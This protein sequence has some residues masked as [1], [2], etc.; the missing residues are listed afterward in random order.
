M[1]TAAEGV[2]E[3]RTQANDKDEDKG[4]FVSE[5]EG[6]GFTCGTMSCLS[7]PDGILA[8]LSLRNSRGKLV[9]SWKSWDV[10][11]RTSARLA[12]E[13]WMTMSH[14]SVRG[15]RKNTDGE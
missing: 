1:K 4:M 3:R 8:I 9:L 5:D 7:Q 13:A 14:C 15:V 10:R 12:K 2:K 6:I 11:T